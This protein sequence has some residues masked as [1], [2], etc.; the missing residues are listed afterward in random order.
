MPY[1]HSLCLPS[2]SNI[3]PG[4]LF[5][6]MENPT[7]SPAARPGPWITLA[8]GLSSGLCAECPV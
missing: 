6:F 4:H 7:L 8:S 1:F 5:L 2:K 3:N